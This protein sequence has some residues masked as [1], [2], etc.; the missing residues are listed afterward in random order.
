MG[1]TKSLPKTKE[2]G[3]DNT[4][5]NATK[6]LQETKE[7][8]GNTRMGANN[9]CHKIL[10]QRKKERRQLAQEWVLTIATKN[11]EK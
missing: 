3:E 2:G 8:G 7:E 9:R 1:A 4:R 5:N 11:K 6:A 10:K